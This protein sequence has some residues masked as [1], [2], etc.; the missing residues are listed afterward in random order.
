MSTLMP[1]LQAIGD[2][3]VKIAAWIRDHSEVVKAAIL[4]IA[5]AFLVV[6]GNAILMGINAA[7]AWFM[8]TWPIALLVAAIALV[9]A[10]LYLLITHIKEVGR[11]FNQVAY[12]IAFHF[13]KVWFTIEHAASKMWK[14]VLE[15]A[16]HALGWIWDKLKAIGSVV[17][18]V[19]TFG[20]AG[21]ASGGLQPAYAGGAGMAMRPSISNASSRSTSHRE[22]NINGPIN[23]HTQA[24][25]AQGIA[26]EIPGALRSNSLL[27]HADGGF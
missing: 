12:D 24:T 27:D 14:S 9:A 8:A 23:I 17:L 11:W 26:K 10:G 3:L 7:I 25:D 18:K 22:T 13:L 20:M 2:V 6:N 5:A 1:A 16:K 15:G 19:A 21:G 4:G